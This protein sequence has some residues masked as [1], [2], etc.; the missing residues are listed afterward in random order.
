MKEVTSLN[1]IIGIQI[2]AYTMK[3]EVRK[4]KKNNQKMY[5]SILSGNMNN[6]IHPIYEEQNERYCPTPPFQ[7][8]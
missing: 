6:L 3:L 8:N 7:T 4:N 1:K 5:S 2:D